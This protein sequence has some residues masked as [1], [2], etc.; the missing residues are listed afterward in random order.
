MKNGPI[1]SLDALE[2]ATDAKGR[3][4]TVHKLP[5]PAKPICVTEEELQGYAFEEGED[6]V[7]RKIANF[8]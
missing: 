7:N 5:I 1:Y 6:T 8:M 3:H 2:A 4:F